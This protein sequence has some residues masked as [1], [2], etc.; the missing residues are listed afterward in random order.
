M[1]TAVAEGRTCTR[2]GEWKEAAKFKR[3]TGTNRLRSNCRACD[4]AAHRQYRDKQVERVCAKCGESYQSRN[5]Q[6]VCCPPCGKAARLAN[7]F[8]EGL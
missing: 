1:T 4:V 8:G 5:G 2:C 6:S 7:L 3:A